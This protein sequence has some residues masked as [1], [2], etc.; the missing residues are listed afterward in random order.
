MGMLPSSQYGSVAVLPSY[1]SSVGGSTAVIGTDI[2]TDN[3]IQWDKCKYILEDEVLT[4]IP[5]SG[6]RW[7]AGFLISKNTPLNT[8]LILEFDYAINEKPIFDYISFTVGASNVSNQQEIGLGRYK[9]T[10]GSWSKVSIKFKLTKPNLKILNI[11]WQ[12][13]KANPNSWM[14]LRNLNISLQD[15]AKSTKWVPAYEDAENIANE[16]VDNTH[17]GILNIIKDG[18]IKR[19]ST[20][21]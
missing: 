13:S 17:I 7:A 19:S 14:R 8:D 9:V 15:G 3:L 5:E 1:I 20:A 18:D 11:G 2:S 10:D 16:V 6:L 4:I 12:G 21:Y